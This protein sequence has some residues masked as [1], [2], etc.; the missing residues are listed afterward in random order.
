M[1]SSD[2]AAEDL[3]YDMVKEDETR[4]EYT[5]NTE[6]D[7]INDDEIL[8]MEED[9]WVKSIK[10]KSINGLP[11]HAKRMHYGVCQKKSFISYV[12]ILHVNS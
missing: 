4:M 6:R 10:V 1:Y 2:N 9:C 11:M 5:I 12:L 7:K 8:S 3:T